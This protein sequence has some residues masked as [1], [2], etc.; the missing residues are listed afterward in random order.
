M[1]IITII[2]VIAAN[3]GEADSACDAT[4]AEGTV[5]A[6]QVGSLEQPPLEVGTK[7]NVLDEERQPH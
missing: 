3:C 2:I 7:R 5:S 6:E 4:L 1:E